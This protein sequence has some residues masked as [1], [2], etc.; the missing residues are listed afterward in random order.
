[1]WSPDSTVSRVTRLWIGR[2]GV[3]IL[4]GARYLCSLQNVHTLTGS[5]LASYSVGI[6]G[7]AAEA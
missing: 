3:Q 2:Y 6:G 5:H 1:M 4:A 7:K